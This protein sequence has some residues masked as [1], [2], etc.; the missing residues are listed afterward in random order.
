MK[1]KDKG[2]APWETRCLDEAH[3]FA[4]SCAELR[5]SNPYGRPTLEV[6]IADLTTELWDRGFSQ[7]EIKSAFERALHDLPQ[8]A[9]GED[10]RGDRR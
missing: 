1:G 7:S 6:V 9:A 8:Y 4:L 10:R 5:Q 3:K 2:E